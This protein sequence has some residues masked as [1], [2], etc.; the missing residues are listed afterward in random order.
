[1]LP[2][3]RQI[4]KRFNY[5]ASFQKFGKKIQVLHVTLL[6]KVM[7]EKIQI[8]DAFYIPKDLRIFFIFGGTFLG[9][10]VIVIINYILMSK[11]DFLE[12]LED[13]VNDNSS[14]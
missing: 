12:V 8:F 5:V 7:A 11:R 13:L 4:R 3:L 6:G 1:M 2:W 14:N 9:K 10:N